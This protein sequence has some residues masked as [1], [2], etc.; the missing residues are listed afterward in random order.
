MKKDEELQ[1]DVLDALRW[2]PLL[3]AAEIGVM[4]NNGI[5]TLTGMVDSYAKK[6]EAEEATKRVSGVRAVVEQIGMS[7]GHWGKTTDADI[8]SDILKVFN[9][10]G[11]IIPAGKVNIMVEDG[12][13]TLEGQ[14]EWNYQK[15]FA[16][17]TIRTLTGV[18]GLTNNII[19]KS[20]VNDRIEKNDIQRALNRNGSMANKDV[21]VNVSGNKV[22]LT[23]SVDSWSKKDEA[24]RIAWNAP[25]V[26]NVDNELV[27]DY[28]D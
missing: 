23:G 18:K 19:I 10:S 15:D 4:V 21:I 14:L 28:I 6:S 9:L 8:A 27:V 24:A 16:K 1:H 12:W 22:T 13:V 20:E 11:G 3:S 25:G 26:W 5:V 7:Y 17:K 2:E